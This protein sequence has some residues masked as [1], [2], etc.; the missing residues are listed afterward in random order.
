[1]MIEKVQTGTN[2]FDVTFFLTINR[3]LG[4]LLNWFVKEKYLGHWYFNDTPLAPHLE[5]AMNEKLSRVNVH[6]YLSGG[7]ERT[8]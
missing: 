1:M 2:H 5:G 8:Q 4:G 3:F 7:C 6:F